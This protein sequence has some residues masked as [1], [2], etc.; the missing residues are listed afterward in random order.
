MTYKTVKIKTTA[1]D[2]PRTSILVIYTGGTL[3]M[4]YDKKGDHLIPFDF[5][6]VL[7]KVP[8][9]N[10]LE[11]ELTVV[12]FDELID[13]SDMKPSN[14]LRI[15]RL[16]YKSY[17]N[18]DSFVV[19]HGTDTM[20]YTASAISYMLENLSKPIIFTGAQLPIGAARTDARENL[21]TALEIASD[22]LYGEPRVPEVCI[23]FNSYLLRGNRAKKIE[24]SHFNA[25]HSENY[26]VLA[27]AGIRID[28]NTPFIKTYQPER[29][30]MMNP[31]MD[32]NVTI[33]KLFPGINQRVVENVLNTENLKGVVL[34]T[35]GS[36]NAPTEAWFLSCLREAVEK[37]IVIFNVSQCTGG[38]V[39][40]GRYQTSK[41]LQELGII[42]GSDITTEAAITKMMYLLAKESNP[43]SVKWQL[44]RSICGEMS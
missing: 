7:E 21:I 35:Y 11:F 44:G 13:S 39:T 36:G 19:I 41:V 40:Q 26:P 3:G 15:A 37:N 28:Y 23:Y 34:E 24:S 12:T 10:R 17:Y 31:E 20:A 42:S 32:D 16:I 8:E 30:L 1:S 6:Q 2:K 14:W 25:F 29:P 27:H 43:E 33:L 9:I 4:V 5:E 18:Y 38:R 22:K